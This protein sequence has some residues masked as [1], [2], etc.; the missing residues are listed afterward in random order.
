MNKGDGIMSETKKQ[1]LKITIEVSEGN[2]KIQ[3]NQ[4]NIITALSLQ[5]ASTIATEDLAK[6]LVELA[7]KNKIQPE[8]EVK[9]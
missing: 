6:L 1:D 7:E 8:E 4:N 2:Y 9:H 3:S 5:E